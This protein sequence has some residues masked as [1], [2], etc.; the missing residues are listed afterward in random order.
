MRSI[1]VVF[2]LLCGTGF[3]QEYYFGQ[4]T[5]KSPDGSIVYL[6]YSKLVHRTYDKENSQIR[7][8][9]VYENPE[10]NYV[11]DQVLLELSGHDFIVTTPNFSGT[12]KLYGQPWAWSGRRA[13][14]DL[15]DGGKILSLDYYVEDQLNSIYELWNS[16]GTLEAVSNSSLNSVSAEEYAKLKAELTSSNTTPTS[17]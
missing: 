13:E 14:F 2:L 11:V 6:T 15:V 16:E 1:G 4:E 17:N 7:E 8:E 9:V 5:M 12:G 3:A 10:G